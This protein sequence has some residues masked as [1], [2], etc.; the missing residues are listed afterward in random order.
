MSACSAVWASG[1]CRSD[2]SVK[3][4]TACSASSVVFLLGLVKVAAFSVASKLLAISGT[5]D[6]AFSARACAR[7]LLRLR[8]DGLTPC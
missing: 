6:R 1:C 4:T 8:R 5:S 7:R 2:L 3:E